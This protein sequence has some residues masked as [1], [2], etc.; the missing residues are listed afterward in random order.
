MP[1]I[2]TEQVKAMRENLKKSL[3][4]FKF[5]VRRENHSSVGVSIMSG[6]DIFK[7]HSYTDVNTFWYKD[8]YE[9]EPEA[10]KV[11]SRVLEAMNEVCQERVESVDGDY[12]NIPNYYQNLCIGK[13]DKPYK[14]K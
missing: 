12:G 4:E 9:S 3:P 8:H 1:Y 13:W 11:F 14:V 10:V 2:S 6:P 5:S 7:D